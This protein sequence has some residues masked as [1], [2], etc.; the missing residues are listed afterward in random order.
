MSKGVNGAVLPLAGI[1]MRD[2]VA[3]FFRANPVGR[4]VH[5]TQ[6][7]VAC[8]HA[9]LLMQRPASICAK[10]PCKIVIWHV[11]LCVLLTRGGVCAVDTC[12]CAAHGGIDLS[13]PP[14]HARVGLCRAAGSA[15]VVVESCGCV[16]TCVCVCVR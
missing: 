7:E 3:E 5:D 12:V 4:F 16:W 14:G 10:G 2:H 9:I 8:V 15:G 13:Q 11:F 1:G 6:S